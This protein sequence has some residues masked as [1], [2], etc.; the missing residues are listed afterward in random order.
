M[1]TSTRR[2]QN[3]EVAVLFNVRQLRFRS[4]HGS[5]LATSTHWLRRAFHGH[6]CFDYCWCFHQVVGNSGRKLNTRTHRQQ[7]VFSEIRFKDLAF[8]DYGEWQ[9][10]T[11][12]I[13]WN[14]TIYEEERNSV[15]FHPATNG[16][17]EHFVQML[18]KELRCMQNELV[19]LKLNGLLM[20][21]R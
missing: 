2:W 4:T 20:Q 8:G 1:T 11:I 21:Y 12:S 16:Q 14:E 5:F 7:Y 6:K 10:T 3:V 19:D 9:W 17:A 18:K 15:L 13:E